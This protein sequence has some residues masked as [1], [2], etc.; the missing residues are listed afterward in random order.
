M[1]PKNLLTLGL[2]VIATAFSTLPA[3]GA[4]QP[5]I[6]FIFADDLAFDAVGYQGNKQVKTPNIDR[7][8]A[9]GT[10]FTHAYNM[11]GWNGAVCIASRTMLNT[12]LT[13][14]RA[15]EA[16][17]TLGK[18]FLKPKKLWSQ[19]LESAGY[20]TYFS[21]KWHV[22]TS[23]EKA[24]QTSRHIRPGMPRSYQKN[25]P[26][27]YD[28]PPADGSPDPWSP[29]DPK[30]GGFWEGGKHWS[31]VLAEDGISFLQQAA[32]DPDPFFMALAFNAPHDPRQA[33]EE[34]VE[35]YPLENISTPTNFLPEYPWSKAMGCG[36]DCRD[37][38]LAPF[39]RTEKI[40][41]IH[42]KEYYAIITHLD[43][44][45]G[46]VLEVLETSGKADETVVIFTADHG[47]AVGQH[48]LLG[49]QNMFEHSLRAPFLIAGAGI[50]AKKTVAA[51][52][53]IQDILPTSLELAGVV[54]P[55]HIEFHSVLPLV[56]GTGG[57]N[58]PQHRDTIYGAFM[59]A[60]RMITQG[61][62]KLIQESL[63]FRPRV[64]P[65]RKP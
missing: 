11:G 56:R 33:P 7:L 8:A 35:K 14:W 29:S 10:V 41:R 20:D 45:I 58:P 3:A 63:A 60:Q 15:K 62:H 37:E 34:Y 38:A 46:R 9:R 4:K 32:K 47:L 51:P 16:S 44:Q 27:A 31:E 23:V 50:P 26:E 1:S 43:A 52:I 39:P 28:R 25:I 57:D 49:K 64:R 24:F 42:R 6:L 17:K 30:W 19:L 21:G 22:A 59:D 65:H 48:G 40:V 61:D 12:G 5:N 53:Y 54:P 55:P 2:A 36:R 18:D 13:L